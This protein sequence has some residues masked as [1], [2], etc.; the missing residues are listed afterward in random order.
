MA[1]RQRE[2]LAAREFP[3][4]W[5][6]DVKPVLAA[7]RRPPLLAGFARH[8]RQRPS[9]AVAPAAAARASSLLD[10]VDALE[11]RLLGA[12]LGAREAAALA[13][14]AWEDVGREVHVP[15]WRAAVAEHA[16]A[17][18]GLRAADL[19]ARARD[20]RP[21]LVAFMPATAN[22]EHLEYESLSRYA[23]QVVTAAVA[24]AMHRAGAT[25]DCLPGE[26]MVLRRGDA[27]F[28]WSSVLL[29][30]AEGGLG[31]ADWLATADR[32]GIRRLDLGDA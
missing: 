28:A 4:F 26:A 7:G 21:F 5:F 10:D 14:V 27:T 6:A 23:D 19:P 31:E 12:A 8:L 9:A 13:P 22:P 16:R 20:L 29:E 25:V 30:L 17:L 3:T 24:V 2:Q 11:Q 32:F 15:R 18:R 1:A